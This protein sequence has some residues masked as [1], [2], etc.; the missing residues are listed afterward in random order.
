MYYFSELPY[1]SQFI[2]IVIMLFMIMAI[3]LLLCFMAN[4][5]KWGLIHFEVFM[6]FIVAALDYSYITYHFRALAEGEPKVGECIPIWV[7]PL[8]A[9][10]LTVF[11]VY[12]H[13]R[14]LKYMRNNFSRSSIRE[15][16]DN[17]P[18]GLCFSSKTGILYLTNRSMYRMAKQ[19]TGQNLTNMERFWN[20]LLEFGEING[21]TKIESHFDKKDNYMVFKM[22]DG[23][24]L[25]V[26]REAIMVEGEENIQTSVTDVSVQYRL[27][28][29]TRLSNEELIN[30]RK[31]IRLITERLI[32]SN[33]EEELLK[34]KI[35]IHNDMGQMILA[36]GN[37]VKDS[38]A[39]MEDYRQLA[40]SWL[41][42]ADRFAH[43]S[44]ISDKGDAKKLLGEILDI[45]EQIG[46]K[47]VFENPLPDAI[48]EEHLLRQLIREAIINGVKH[49]GADTVIIGFADNCLYIKNNGRLPD[50]KVQ[51]HGGLLNLSEG[52]LSI[53]GSLEIDTETMFTLKIHLGGANENFN[54]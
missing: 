16:L 13:F 40:D 51:L 33:H 54:S 37:V 45:S 44:D 32:Q 38:S 28:E 52:I 35:Q 17:M 15:A 9:V 2:Y 24:F 25:Q 53:G 47:V 11:T 26:M 19:L 5:R 34:H 36:T 18:M 42:L 20:V 43:M 8:I 31:E 1:I 50:G 48:M 12:G 22:N 3:L 14:N 41:K 27:L 30:Q 10:A 7:H 46:C 23:S 39:E 49:G 4:E 6:V 29:E 21:N